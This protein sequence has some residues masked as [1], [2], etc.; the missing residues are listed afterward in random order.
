[1]LRT[2]VGKS[3]HRADF[4]ECTSS[5]SRGTGYARLFGFDCD[6]S[7]PMCSDDVLSGWLLLRAAS[8]LGRRMK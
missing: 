7:P 1:M 4:T 6:R 3:L 8:C 2:S 5:Q